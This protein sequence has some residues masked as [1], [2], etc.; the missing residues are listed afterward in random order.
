MYRMPIVAIAVSIIPSDPCGSMQGFTCW[1]AYNSMFCRSSSPFHRKWLFNLV[2]CDYEDC[3]QADLLTVSLLLA[4]QSS[5][6]FLWFCRRLIG[7]AHSLLTE[8]IGAVNSIRSV[9]G[10]AMLPIYNPNEYCMRTTPLTLTLVQVHDLFRQLPIRGIDCSKFVL[11][12]CSIRN[13]CKLFIFD[14]LLSCS[15]AICKNG[16][17]KQRNNQIEWVPCAFPGDMLLADICLAIDI[18]ATCFAKANTGILLLI[19]LYG[20]SL[21]TWCCDILFQWWWTIQSHWDNI[22]TSNAQLRP[23]RHGDSWHGQ[24]TFIALFS[25]LPLRIFSRENL[26]K[27]LALIE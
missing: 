14:L 11:C 23:V 17:S 26:A 12:R 2:C 24:A 7:L 4:R 16:Q 25:P 21:E 3:E 22:N 15:F 19:D 1:L 6:R 9:D 20:F 8:C 27:L 5:Q 10:V 13:L 18:C